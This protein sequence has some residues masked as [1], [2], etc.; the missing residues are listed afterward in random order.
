MPVHSAN[1]RQAQVSKSPRD[2]DCFE[3]SLAYHLEPGDHLLNPLHNF[4]KNQE[5]STNPSASTE[6][7][8]WAGLSMKAKA[9]E[10]T[11]VTGHLM[12]QET[13]RFPHDAA[14]PWLPQSELFS[15]ASTTIDVHLGAG[16]TPAQLGNA[17]LDFFAE[18]RSDAMVVLLQKVRPIKFSVKAEVTTV[19]DYLKCCVKARIYRRSGSHQYAIEFQRRAGDIVAF[20]AIFQNAVQFYKGRGYTL[21]G[22]NNSSP[23]PATRHAFTTSHAGGFQCLNSPWE[24]DGFMIEPL[25]NIAALQDQPEMQAEAGSALARV[26][27]DPAGAKALL[28]HKN[29]KDAVQNLLRSED[30]ETLYST[31]QLLLS[32]LNCQADD[33]FADD[34][35]W[36]SILRKM[37]TKTCAFAV[38]REMEKVVNAAAQHHM[39]RLTPHTEDIFPC[40]FPGAGLDECRDF[41]I[42]DARQ[43]PVEA[44]LAS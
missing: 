25:L 12:N 2:I 24:P 34:E 20:N 15:L 16:S 13:I 32:M 36:A 33:W 28:Q 41:V 10:G 40:S 1:L 7:L 22:P 3:N 26:V 35:L 9:V 11:E 29:G 44:N 14:P 30:Q 21:T 18:S 39:D 23:G 4:G 17:L 5:T 43:A 38:R 6:D 8:P 19:S 42:A 31:S 27:R 37:S